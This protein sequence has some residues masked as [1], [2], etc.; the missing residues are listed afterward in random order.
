M[1]ARPDVDALSVYDATG[2]P[3]AW[4]GRPSN[5]PEERVTGAE[6]LFVAPG[7]AGLRLVHIR[8][9]TEIGS[10]GRRLGSV[11]A[12]RLLTRDGQI[13]GGDQSTFTFETA[14]V[15]APAF[16]AMRNVPSQVSSRTSRP[17]PR[18]FAS[19]PS[20]VAQSSRHASIVNW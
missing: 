19:S 3:V 18:F 12:E 2:R 17:A 11:A 15:P 4:A 9:V 14:Q 5:L 6:A 7:P 1:Q 8:P 13:R 16:S 20:Q 10:Q